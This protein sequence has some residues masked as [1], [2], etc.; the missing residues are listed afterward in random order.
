MIDGAEYDYEE[1][2]RFTKRA[3]DLA[4]QYNIPVEAELGAIS[5]K[6]DDHVS[7]SDLKTNVDQVVEYVERTGC[8]MLA[9]SVGN[10]HGLDEEPNID[11]E[12]LQK[13]YEVSPVP[14]VIHGGSGISDAD[15]Q[16][17]SNY[18][19]VKFN[20]ASDLR[21]GYIKSIGKAF[22][23]NNNEANLIKVLIEATDEVEKIVYEKILSINS[24][25]A[26][27]V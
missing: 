16:K 21:N 17:M 27:N 14:I 4:K 12:L 23:S 8:D 3:V 19:V 10:V 24:M 1:N 5:G 15:I 13:F 20:I 11:F 18:G 26:I 7:E 2:I 25:E 6:E 9:V 22:D